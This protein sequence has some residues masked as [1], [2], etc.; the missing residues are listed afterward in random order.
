MT[1][2]PSVLATQLGAR[3]QYA[4]PAAFA[5]TDQLEA[6]YT[7]LC[8]GR[9]IGRLAPVLGA[10]PPLARRFNIARRAPPPKVLRRTQAF[11]S[12]FWDMRR[13]LACEQDP[14]ARLH[15]LRAAHERAAS[16]MVQQGFGNASHVLA[17]FGEA[18]AFQRSAKAQG[19]ITIT[20]MNIAPST[21]AIVQ[22]EQQNYPD[23]EAPKV[24]Y[25]QTVH[26]IAPIMD[27]V[28]A[29]T[30]IFLCPSPFV[31]DDLIQNFGVAPTSARLVPYAVNPKW[32]LIKPEPEVGQILFVGGAELRKGIHVL[33][34]AAQLLRARGRNYTISVAGFAR[35]ELRARPE[36]DALSFLGR[37]NAT[38]LEQ[39]YRKADMVVLPSLAEGSA[40][41][42]Y[43]AL[44]CALPVI[45]TYEA[46]SVVRDGVDGVI[47]PS[48]DPVAL[49]DAIE[50]VV[51]NRSLRDSMAQ[52]ARLRAAAFSWTEFG[53]ALRRAVFEQDGLRAR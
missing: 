42:T 6:L 45:T 7:D 13:A 49:A 41:V 46:G 12:W 18:T 47:V 26:G 23:W 25:G 11:P 40:G 32:A 29:A 52:N 38:Q 28:L 22:A 19:L 30:D 16:K 10:I 2:R 34:G 50:D 48:R 27:A 53:A 37:L 35:S 5:Q 1:E 4:V 17:M 51:Q 21:E 8:A 3:R 15:Q 33:A 20:D 24:Y 36:C 9:G 43:E 14:I 39:A 44:G 31:R